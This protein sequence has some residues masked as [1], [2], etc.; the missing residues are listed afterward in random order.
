MDA[1]IDLS[2]T[3]EGGAQNDKD[4]LGGKRRLYPNGKVFSY[5]KS[6]GR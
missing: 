2:K 5:I 4:A 6:D 1:S 3:G